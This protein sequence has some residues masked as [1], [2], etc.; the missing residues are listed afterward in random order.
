MAVSTAGHVFIGA[1]ALTSRVRLGTLDALY[2][3]RTSDGHP[4]PTCFPNNHALNSLV[5]HPDTSLR[6]QV[7]CTRNV[8]TFIGPMNGHAWWS[9]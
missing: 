7:Q 6:H 1:G 4:I 8:M 2:G 9:H 5:P 3:E